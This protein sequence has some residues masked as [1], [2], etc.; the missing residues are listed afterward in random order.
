MQSQMAQCIRGASAAW[1][2][3]H[4]AQIQSLAFFAI[5][6]W[7]LARTLEALPAAPARVLD[8]GCG[9]GKLALFIAAIEATMVGP[10]GRDKRNL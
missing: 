8:L 4:I 2:I 5:A 6:L 1:R 3:Q 9:A 10:W 7:L